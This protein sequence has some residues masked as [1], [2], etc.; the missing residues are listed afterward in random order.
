MVCG[1]KV[2][3]FTCGLFGAAISCL[4]LI[5]QVPATG[6]QAATGLDSA[7]A[8][9]PK[10]ARAA[11]AHA[12]ARSSHLS[13]DQELYY[14]T[15]WGVDSLRVKSVESGQ[16]IRFSYRITIPQKAKIVNEKKSDP[17]LYDPHSRVRLVVP[18]MD[19]VGQLR[20]S[21]APEAGKTYWMVFSNKGGPVK[22]GDRVS[23]VIGKFRVDGLMVE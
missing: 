15:L 1:Q 7:S 14:E 23:V 12:S 18:V 4:W 9:V 10:A 6:Q 16:M 5:V 17:Y 20:Q 13:P 22:K 11:H 19:K 21:S 8:S 3:R 2:A